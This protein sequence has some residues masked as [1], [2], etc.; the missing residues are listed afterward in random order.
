M[1]PKNKFQK[2]ILEA[3]K[4]LPAISET[5][6]KWAYQNCIE[7][8]GYRTKSGAI[9]C[10]EC[11]RKWMDSKAEKYCICPDCKTKLVIKDTLKKLFKDCQYFCIIT[12]CNGFQI[13][14]YFYIS[15]YAKSGK[16]ANYFQKEVAQ[17]WIAPN[18]RNEVIARLQPVL[19]HGENWSMSSNLEIRRKRV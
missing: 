18:G 11:S 6:I 13:L 1:K 16:K 4:K 2:Q 10:L 9:T 7:H 8:F 14:R 5:Q 12:T 3:S 19:Y 17:R 15:Y